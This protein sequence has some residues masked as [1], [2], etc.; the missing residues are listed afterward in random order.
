[1][2]TEKSKDKPKYIR[3]KPDEPRRKYTRRDPEEAGKPYY[4]AKKTPSL[5]K[6][7]Y[8]AAVDVLIKNDYTTIKGDFFYNYHI[9]IDGT[10]HRM[11]ADQ[12]KNVVRTARIKFNHCE[13]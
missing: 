9:L 5:P 2:T 3:K 1:M 10:W 8:H 4:R 11:S 7:L 6:S 12:L 13:D